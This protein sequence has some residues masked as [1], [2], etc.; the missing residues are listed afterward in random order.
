MLLAMFPKYWKNT[1][2]YT[3]LYMQ[4]TLP[5]ATLVHQYGDTS[6]LSTF[7]LFRL[8]EPRSHFRFAAAIVLITIYETH[9]KV[10]LFENAI[11]GSCLGVLARVRVHDVLRYEG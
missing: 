6:G 4:I 10:V 8:P 11:I 7:L 2:Q 1:L 9:D 5:N 3:P